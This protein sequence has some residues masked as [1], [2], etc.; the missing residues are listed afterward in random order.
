MQIWSCKLSDRCLDSIQKV[1]NLFL[2]YF[3]LFSCLSTLDLL[4]TQV[5]PK[6]H[7]RK[8][9]IKPCVR[10]HRSLCSATM[11]MPSIKKARST[12]F[13]ELFFE[14]IVVRSSA[15]LRLRVYACHGLLKE[16][17][18]KCE[19][20]VAWCHTYSTTIKSI[21]NKRR[22]LWSWS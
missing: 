2:V 19:R 14:R 22:D 8:I 10:H 4:G 3:A 12:N 18:G 16:M 1:K 21:K 15:I 17:S 7:S 11:K 6:H 5:H 9:H 13:T 20:Y